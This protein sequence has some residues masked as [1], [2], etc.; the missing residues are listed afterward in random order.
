MSENDQ[1]IIERLQIIDEKYSIYE[2]PATGKQYKKKEVDN[3]KS[4]GGEN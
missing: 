1:E 4:E 3:L 2:D